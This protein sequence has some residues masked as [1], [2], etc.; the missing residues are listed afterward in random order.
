MRRKIVI[1]IGLAILIIAA[2]TII[3]AFT[4]MTGTPNPEPV[5]AIRI[6]PENVGKLNVND[7][8]TVNVTI[9]NCVDVFAVQ[10]DLRYNSQ[11]LNVT[12]ILE[13]PFLTSGG[14]TFAQNITAQPVNTTPPTTRLFFVDTKLG[15]EPAASGNGT[16]LTL[17]FQVLSD[18]S[19][20]LQFFPYPVGTGTTIGTYFMKRDLTE[21]IP[22]LHNGSY[23]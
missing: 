12:N 20:Q 15:D 23:G 14:S 3:L 11:V 17:T 9:E 1:T 7:T 10:V 21:I 22:K 4:R 19:S 8:F 5:T 16:L 13:G 2:A 6:E 18:G